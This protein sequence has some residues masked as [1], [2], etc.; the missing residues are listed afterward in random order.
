M[1][2]TI[3]VFVL[4]FFVGLLAGFIDSIAGGGGLISLPALL[5]IGLPPQIA[6]GTNKL[7]GTFGVCTAAFNF[8]RKGKVNLRECLLGVLATLV[9][10]MIGAYTIQ[11]LDSE[12]I[13]NLVPFLLLFVLIYTAFSKNLGFEDRKARLSKNLFYLWF[14]LM[15]GFYDGFFGPG[16]GSFWTAGLMILLGFNITKAVGVTKVM[17]FT[18]N[19]VAL[20]VFSLKGNVLISVGITMAAGQIIGARVGSSLAIKKGANFIRPLFLL[21]V[22]LTI[23][24]LLYRNYYV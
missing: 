5:F 20:I 10:A 13:G 7:Q 3:E 23:I 14:G 2:L 24:R 22:L 12:F 16:T 9:G 21:I 19:L 11:R 1:E 8:V 6:L 18:S 4:L 17:N 15:L